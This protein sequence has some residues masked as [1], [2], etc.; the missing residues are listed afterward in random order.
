MNVDP[1]PALAGHVEHAA[2]ELGQPARQRQA[3]TRA[4]HLRLQ[5]VFELG[6]LLE[7]PRLV[8][9]RDADAGVRDREGD[10]PFARP[11]SP[12]MTRTSPRSVNFKAF[13]IRL[14]RI[15]E[16]LPSSVKSGGSAVASSNT[17]E[18]D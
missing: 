13:E 12:A 5:T 18:T 3:E 11:A 2:E 16:T 14:R 9:R 6:E 1:S 15:C 10:E 17:S 4:A 8:L 7:D